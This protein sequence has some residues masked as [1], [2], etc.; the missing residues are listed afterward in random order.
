[1]T[2]QEA[3][4]FSST[5]G[6]ALDGRLWLP[7][8]Q[9]LAIIQLV[10]G[11][12]EHID[13]YDR[14]A[15]WLNHHGIAVTGHTHLGHGPRAEIQGHFSDRDGWQHL[16][17]DVHRLRQQT[18]ARFPDVPYFILGHSMGSFVTR[19]YLREHGEGLAGAIL[20]GTGYFNR[21]KLTAGLLAANLVCLFGGA[22]KPS[23]LID[24]LTFSTSNRPFA[25]N[26]TPFDWLSRDDAEVDRYIA[27]P[28]CGF[29][30]TG[31]G[32]RELFRGLWRLTDLAPLQRIPQTL[33]LLMIS[34][35]ADPV[36]GMGKGVKRVAGQFR[37][38]GLR[39]VE[40]KLYP[41]ARHEL[42]NETNRD[43]VCRDV[44]DFVLRVV[45]AISSS[46]MDE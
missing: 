26:R 39:Q 32:Y 25:P 3:F 20:C 38:A 16:I 11:M 45:K 14:M 46:I 24:R 30:F 2:Q 13:R 10:H 36:G 27:D 33:P 35:D 23:P 17:D 5:A 34:G 40:L 31:S 19:C 22:R 12:A 29:P 43:E 7:D 41:G 15:R 44:A 18:Q 1:M 6:P 9:P 8:G 28:Y 21:A 42:F 4:T 37:E